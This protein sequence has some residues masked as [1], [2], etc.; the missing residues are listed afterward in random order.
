[1][2]SNRKSV[3]LG[4]LGGVIGVTGIVTLFYCALH[5]NSY[6]GKVTGFGWS[7]AIV[8]SQYKTFVE[9]SCSP[10]NGSRI[11]DSW[12]E[13]YTYSKSSRGSDGNYKTTWH[14]GFRRRYKYEIDRWSQIETRQTEGTS[15]D[16]IWADVSD[17]TTSTFVGAKREEYRREA[18]SIDLVDELKTSHKYYLPLS[19]FGHRFIG[20]PVMLQINHFGICRGYTTLEED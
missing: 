14:T 18:Y 5:T 7:R 8:I 17:T 2:V 3:I 6:S 19:E 15:H 16:P 20:E 12:M 1:M 11:L 4:I 10:P 9:N 13:T